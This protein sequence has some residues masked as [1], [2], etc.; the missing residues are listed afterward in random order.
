MHTAATLECSDCKVSLGRTEWKNLT[1]LGLSLIIANKNNCTDICKRV[2]E[3]NSKSM[4]Y[5]PFDKVSTLL[6]KHNYTS[7]I[8]ENDLVHQVGIPLNQSG[9]V[10]GWETGERSFSC[11]CTYDS[12]CLTGVPVGKV[13]G[14]GGMA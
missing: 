3:R 4:N 12:D 9:S 11:H 8:N 13:T 5:G 7:Y 6:I 14:S 2:I 1:G 10:D